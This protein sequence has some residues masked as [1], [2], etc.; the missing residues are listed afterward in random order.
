MKRNY[1]KETAKSPDID[2]SS[3]SEVETPELDKKIVNQFIA[4]E[5]PSIKKP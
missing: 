4:Q 5:Q 3:D 1:T 2:S